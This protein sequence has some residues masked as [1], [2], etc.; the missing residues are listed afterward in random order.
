MDATTK[1]NGHP[2]IS[3]RE[4][5]R[6]APPVN[7]V[8]C[9]D[10]AELCARMATALARAGAP[11]ITIAGATGEDGAAIGA[12][13]PAVA[14]EQAALHP[15]ELWNPEFL[16]S[17]PGA[18]GETSN[19]ETARKHGLVHV[20]ASEAALQSIDALDDGDDYVPTSRSPRRHLRANRRRTATRE[21]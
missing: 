3:A 5:A 7:M 2:Q 14:P 17:S 21:S 15:I 6:A 19:A 20:P 4:R 10:R 12:N 9:K 1:G 13:F 8:A 16:R 11:P 18:A